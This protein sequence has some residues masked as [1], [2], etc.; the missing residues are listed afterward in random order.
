[1]GK[2]HLLNKKKMTNRIIKILVEY[3]N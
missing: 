2:I 1:M 3:T